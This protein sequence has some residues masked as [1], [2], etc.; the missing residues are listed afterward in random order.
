MWHAIRQVFYKCWH[1]ECSF[2]SKAI[3]DVKGHQMIHKDKPEKGK[4]SKWR[5]A[6]ACKICGKV[7]PRSYLYSRHYLVHSDKKEFECGFCGKFFKTPGDL[8]AHMKVHGADDEKF[9]HCCELCGKRFTQRANLDAHLRVHSGFKPF[10]C[11]FCNKSFSQKGNMEEHRRTH[12]G[13]KPYVCE[14]CAA[15]FVRRSGQSK[16]EF[17]SM[18][19]FL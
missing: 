12:T 13:E 6:E 17:A 7:Y 2:T 1:E 3:A 18:Y 15:A 16:L 11:D 14:I 10:A 4:D 8:K 5:T 19:L 9:R